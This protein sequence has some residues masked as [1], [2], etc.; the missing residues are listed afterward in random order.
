MDFNNIFKW[1]LNSFLMRESTVDAIY[2]DLLKKTV[3]IVMKDGNITMISLGRKL[4]KQLGYLSPASVYPYLDLIKRGYIYGTISWNPK[5]PPKQLD[6]LAIL[7]QELQILENHSLIHE[8]KEL[9]PLFFEY[10]PTN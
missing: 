4:F 9:E 6:R 5:N 1:H 2:S 8:L 10:P 7:L 3:N